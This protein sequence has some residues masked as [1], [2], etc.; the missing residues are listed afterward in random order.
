MS[1]Q[2][3][4]LFPFVRQMFATTITLA[5]TAFC[6]TGGAAAISITS[7]VNSDPNTVPVAGTSL[8]DGDFRLTGSA[9]RL[10]DGL[11]DIAFWDFDF[12]GDPN[13][14]IF[15][16]LIDS[17]SSL[18][19]ANLSLTM[20]P[21]NSLSTDATGIT[22]IIGPSVLMQGLSDI[23]AVGETGI[24]EIDLFSPL[25]GPNNLRFTPE[26][27]LSAFNSGT[28]K[29]IPWFF[30]DDARISSATLELV[31][32]SSSLEETSIPEPSSIFGLGVLGVALLVK[33]KQS[34]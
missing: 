10:G 31:V 29:S 5:T 9:G 1:T 22:R 33:Q 20:T 6:F 34:V 2:F 16:N 24:L 27:I 14:D 8:Q 12:N 15:K 19:S 7:T 26:K 23:P 25:I 13:V 30:Q 4:S 18:L 11:D 3:K 21:M 32:D 28:P 17:G